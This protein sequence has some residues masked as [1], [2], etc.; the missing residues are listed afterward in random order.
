M[1][2]CIFRLLFVPSVAYICCKK[3]FTQHRPKNLQSVAEILSLTSR[4]PVYSVHIQVV[5][6]QEIFASCGRVPQVTAA[7]C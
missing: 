6:V 1:C 2:L 4:E 5:A 7:A 3:A